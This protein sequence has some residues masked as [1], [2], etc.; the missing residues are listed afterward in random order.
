MSR[1]LFLAR[2]I[3][4]AKSVLQALLTY[5]MQT[6]IL[7][8]SVC[9]ELDRKCFIWGDSEDCRKIHVLGWNHLCQPK[10]VVGLGLRSARDVNKVTI[11]KAGWRLSTIRHTF[12]ASILW[13]KYK[14]GRGC[15]PKVKKSASGSN[16]W[17]GVCEN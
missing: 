3:M 12:W 4:L 5:V 9:E 14:C 10:N 2:R 16:F 17:K 13:Y 7:P 8:I 15:L 6:V 11:V 1:N